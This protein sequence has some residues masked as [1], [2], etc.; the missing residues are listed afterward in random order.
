MC[1]RYIVDTVSRKMV[2]LTKVPRLLIGETRRRST[3]RSSRGDVSFPSFR[4]IYGDAATT[5][6]SKDDRPERRLS[7]LEKKNSALTGKNRR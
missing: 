7:S 5:L 3:I 4:S 6:D 2:A 1:S